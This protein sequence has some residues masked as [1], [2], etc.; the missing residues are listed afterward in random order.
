MSFSELIKS[1]EM[2]V[3]EYGPIK[4]IISSFNRVDCFFNVSSPK[5]KMFT[6]LKTHPLGKVDNV[7]LAI[8]KYF[9]IEKNF[10]IV[11]NIPYRKLS[12]KS[13]I[14]GAK[15]GVIFISTEVRMGGIAE[16]L[17]R[18]EKRISNKGKQLVGKDALF[19]SFPEEL[20][21][22]NRRYRFRV[23]PRIEDHFC[24]VEGYESNRNSPIPNLLLRNFSDLGSSII[25][26]GIRKE[27][28][29]EVGDE[30]HVRITLFQPAKGYSPKSGVMVSVD[31]VREGKV[32]EQQYVF[33]SRVMHIK[34][35][36][37]RATEVGV[38]FLKMA[39]E[40]VSVEPDK[41]P[42]L[43]YIP[44]DREKGIE[45]II[46]WISRLQQIL[47]SREKELAG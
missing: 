10:L 30:I 14:I 1:P 4:T 27:A 44:I 20:Y 28:L 46:V 36:N 19:L 47:R 18:T 6:L 32:L 42:F 37:E 15:V 5:E 39:R 8:K 13:V 34:K 22:V 24:E 21:S 9:E 38:Q 3:K 23:N 43:T 16:I 29:P 11:E 7:Y 2:T 25:F 33:H 40:G 26:V 31:E 35:R 41:F 45:P 17:Y 12:K